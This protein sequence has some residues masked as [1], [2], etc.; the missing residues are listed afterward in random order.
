[1]IRAPL[2]LHWRYLR[3]TKKKSKANDKGEHGKWKHHLRE[4]TAVVDHLTYT[5][6]ESKNAIERRWHSDLEILDAS[7]TS[8]HGRST[9]PKDRTNFETSHVIWWIHAPVSTFEKT[10]LASSSC[11]SGCSAMI[12][13]W[14]ALKPTSPDFGFTAFWIIQHALPRAER[15]CE[16]SGM[17]LSCLMHSWQRNIRETNNIP[18]LSENC[19]TTWTVTA[20]MLLR[21]Q[22]ET[23]FVKRLTE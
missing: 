6:S 19:E 9:L 12:R 13:F 7:G 8:D 21:L 14:Q 18:V 23:R 15:K 16:K 4:N 10:I 17:K 5:T 1:M 3:E 20:E 2:T 11:V 22:M